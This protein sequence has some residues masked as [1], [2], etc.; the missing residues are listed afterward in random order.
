[1]RN[2]APPEGLTYRDSHG[3]LP[4]VDAVLWFFVAGCIVAL[5]LLP[6]GAEKRDPYPWG[7]SAIAWMIAAVAVV[8][9]VATLNRMKAVTFNRE[10]GIV[11]FWSVFFGRRHERR[12]PL[13]GFTQVGVRTWIQTGRNGIGRCYDLDLRGPKQR[14]SLAEYI[15]ANEVANIRAIAAYLKLPITVENRDPNRDPRSEL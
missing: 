7:P 9:G 13:S 8:G 6:L 15:P 3:R 4:I 14:Q 11:I 12:I 2:T 10:R 5:T 1:V